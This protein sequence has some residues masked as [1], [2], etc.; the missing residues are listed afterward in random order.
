M[1][2]MVNNPAATHRF[3]PPQ[4]LYSFVERLCNI[5]GFVTALCPD[6]DQRPLA[7]ARYYHVRRVAWLAELLYEIRTSRGD[8]LDLGKI[9]WLSWAHDLNRWPFAHNSEKG[10]FD[11]AQDVSRYL[12]ENK[13]VASKNYQEELKDIIDKDYSTLSVEG[14]I[15]LLADIVAGFIEDPLWITTALDVTPKIIPND[16]SDYICLPV[17]QRGFLQ[18]LLELNQLF[19]E[20]KT[21]EPFEGCFDKL[22]CTIAERFTDDKQLALHLPLGHPEFEHWRYR[23]KEGFM[24]KVLFK[25]NNERVSRGS[26]LRKDITEPLLEHVGE[27]STAFFTSIDEPQVMKKAVDIGIISAESVSEYFPVLN[28]IE[29]SEPENSFHRTFEKT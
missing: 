25:Y 4:D 18:H 21:V 17:N 5:T 23:I 26:I 6:G 8:N 13:I 28:Y 14:K 16:I 15:V 19:R 29:M 27:A 1:L 12:S 11:Q 24:R 3:S 22:F 9:R 10:L 20:T 2:S 7:F